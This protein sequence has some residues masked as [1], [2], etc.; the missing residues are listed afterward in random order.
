MMIWAKLI[1][2]EDKDVEADKVKGTKRRCRKNRFKKM[3][4]HRKDEMV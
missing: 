4:F 3:M 1:E 2:E